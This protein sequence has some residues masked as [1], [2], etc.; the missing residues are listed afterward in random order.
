MEQT[1]RC[2][3]CG[4]SLNY[5]GDDDPAVTCAYCSSTVLVPEE[6]RP[7]RQA[8]AP[9]ISMSRTSMSVDLGDLTG[10][11]AALKIVR[12]LARNGRQEEAATLYSKT[13]GASRQDAD[14][15][16]AQLASGQSVAVS[17]TSF[18]LPLRVVTGTP[19][20]GSSSQ[21]AARAADFLLNQA[22]IGRQ[23]RRQIRFVV[24]AVVIFVL[25][26]VFL[27]LSGTIG[28]FL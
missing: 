12:G 23:L 21:Q 5:D 15:L 2:P 19:S 10:A 8:A 3:S 25:V 6:L 11:I 26:M 17:N 7:G 9:F 18:G 1:F 16:V 14:A 28:R 24:I 4:A 20:Q 13:F 22:G 27:S